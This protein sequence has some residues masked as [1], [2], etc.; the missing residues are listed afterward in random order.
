MIKK[1]VVTGATRG[2]GFAISEK[3]LNN[4]IHVT[5]TGTHEKNMGPPGSE[6]YQVDFLDDKSTT[7]FVS[8]LS[9]EIRKSRGNCLLS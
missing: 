9:K 2:I 3:L 5:A 6:Y 8:Y 7:D 1:A 4:N